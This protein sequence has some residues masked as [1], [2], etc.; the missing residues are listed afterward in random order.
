MDEMR[1]SSRAHHL[2]VLA[3]L[4]ATAAAAQQ[5]P[6]SATSS[7][8]VHKPAARLKPAGPSDGVIADGVYHNAFFGFSCKVPYGWVDRTSEMREDEQ[9]GKALLLLATFE[10]PPDATGNTVN[11]AVIITAESVASYPGLKTAVDYFGP[12]TE[13]TNSK[14]FKVVN[15]PYTFASGA[16]QLVRGDFSKQIGTLTM[17]QSSLVLVEKSYVVSFTFIAGNDGEINSLIENLAFGPTRN[18]DAG[19]IPAKK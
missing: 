13:L 14:G 7:S 15:E 16:K 11:S 5:I 6:D 1:S 2:L 8:R 10:R 9:P 4:L 12:L 3:L 18:P 19:K 17:Q